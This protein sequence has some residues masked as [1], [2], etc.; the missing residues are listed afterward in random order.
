VLSGVITYMLGSAVSGVPTVLATVIG[1][2]W[3][4]PLLAIGSTA[5][6]VLVSPLTSIVATLVYFDLR[7]RQEGFDL[8]VMAREV[9]PH[10]AA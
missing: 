9:G 4:F 2:R 3:G 5:S 7:I 8:Q 10:G 1:Y 6:A